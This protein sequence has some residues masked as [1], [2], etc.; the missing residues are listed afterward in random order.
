LEKA[1]LKGIFFRAASSLD[2]LNRYAYCHNNPVKY[3]DPTGNITQEQGMALA[4]GK[5]TS[6]TTY[7]GDGTMTTTW[8]NGKTWTGPS[9]NG[10]P[11]PTPN[12]PPT[13]TPTISPDEDKSSDDDQLGP[14]ALNPNKDKDDKDDNDKNN[15]NRHTKDQEA[16]FELI[17][18]K[19]KNGDRLTPA[20]AEIVKGWGK[21][22]GW[23]PEDHTSP[24]KAK[25]WVKGPHIHIGPIDHVPVD[26]KSSIEAIDAGRV[27]AI[28]ATLGMI[29]KA[30]EIVSGKAISPVMNFC[31]NNG[32]NDMMYNYDPSQVY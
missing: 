18:S 9:N 28:L 31:P 23:E 19:I 32:I 3:V 20:E 26:K 2:G 12:Q 5:A 30:A 8:A 4:T 27:A 10:N 24:E 22:V 7:N 13:P 15:K 6:V 29:A 16:L 21:E 11:S 25:H 1:F 17:K 14:L